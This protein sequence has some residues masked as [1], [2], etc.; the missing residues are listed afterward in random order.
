MFGSITMIA[1]S[2]LVA[3]LAYIGLEL[4]FGGS[5]RP[6]PIL[7]YGVVVVPLLA[8]AYGV[9]QLVKAE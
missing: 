1:I 9:Y 4:A 2:L 3:G 8:A 5:R 7:Y 6:V